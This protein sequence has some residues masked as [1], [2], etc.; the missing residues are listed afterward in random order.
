[1]KNIIGVAIFALATFGFYQLSSDSFEQSSSVSLANVAALQAN[2]GEVHCDQRD[3]SS[4][5]IRVGDVIGTSTGSV[6]NY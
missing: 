1:M 3:Q 6:R 5:S 2:A 4:C